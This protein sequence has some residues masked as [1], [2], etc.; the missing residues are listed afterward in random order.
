MTVLVPPGIYT[1]KLSVDGQEFSQPLTV[2]KD[3]NA[4]GTDADIQ[5]Q[6][7]MLF[8][9]RKDLELGADM[10]NQIENI[11]GQ[12]DRLRPQLSDASLKAAGDDLEKKLIEI[13]DNLIQ[14]KF[15][16]Q[17]QDTTRYP[18]KLIA[19]INYLASGVSGGD[20]PPNTQQMEVHAMFKT[21]LADLRKR[22][23]GV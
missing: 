21:Q 5:K 18:P 11:R 4:G 14:R 7:A 23:D 2:L 6:T 3:P 22:L 1:V 13:E 19:K 17:G 16:G 12:L 9:L 20:Y 8:D 10:V 15:T